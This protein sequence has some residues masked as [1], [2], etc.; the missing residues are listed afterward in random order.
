MLKNQVR[1]FN[2]G[3]PALRNSALR[4][5]DSTNAR[6]A[7]P[8]FD[9]PALK[10]KFDVTLIIDRDD[11]AISNGYIKADVSGPGPDKHTV[12]FST[13]PPMSTYLVAMAVGDFQCSEGSA[14]NIPI[15]VCGTPDKKPLHAAALR[16][17]AEILKYYNQYYGVPYPFRKLDIVGAPDFEAGAMENTGAIF[18]RESL[19]FI[20]DN[21]SSVK[22]HQLVFEVLAH[23]MAHQWFGDLVTMKW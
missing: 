2:L 19:L 12:K 5:S 14:D 20:D 9:E 22:E 4:Q 15:R 3:Q 7:V 17:A 10:A 21:N 18:Y 13:T 16:Y 11:T 23:E 1:V 6:R 8:S